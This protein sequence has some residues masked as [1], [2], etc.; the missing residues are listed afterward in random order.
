MFIISITLGF[1]FRVM[2]CGNV[3]QAIYLQ[4]V[5]FQGSQ[6]S[7]HQHR[8]TVVRVHGKV[9]PETQQIHV[10]AKTIYHEMHTF[11]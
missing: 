1:V 9:S 5:W 3:L 10:Q 2:G 7:A 11:Y 4:Y 8:C 6:L